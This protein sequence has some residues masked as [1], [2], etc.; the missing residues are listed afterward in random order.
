MVALNY[1]VAFAMAEGLDA[2]LARIDALG[3]SDLA[4]RGKL[5]DYHLYHAARADILRRLGRNAEAATAYREAL[6]LVSN[7]VER[8]YLRRRL[9][10]VS[11]G[12]VTRAE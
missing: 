10:E 11:S 3:A 8:A 9:A 5:L 2:G 4:N 1:A 7:D 12:H 6:G